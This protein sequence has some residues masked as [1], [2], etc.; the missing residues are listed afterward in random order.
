[1]LLARLIKVEKF[2]NERDSLHDIYLVGIR[3]NCYHYHSLFH[4]I[5]VDIIGR[6]SVA[7]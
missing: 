6:S 2:H 4:L 7:S 3:M 5:L 1:M